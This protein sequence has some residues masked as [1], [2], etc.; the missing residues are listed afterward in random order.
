MMGEEEKVNAATHRR[1]A[2]ELFN[3]T[4]DLMEKKDRMKEE[5]ER[6]VHAA[7]SSR[8][9]W[10]E[11]GEPLNLAVGEWQIARVYSTLKRPS[12]ALRHARRCLEIIEETGIT[13]FYCAS[14]YEG[15]AKATAS[16]ARGRRAR[17]TLGS[18]RPRA[19]ASRT[20]RRGR[21]SWTSWQKSP[22]TVNDLSLG[23]YRST[24]TSSP[25]VVTG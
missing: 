5:D 6:M 20:R 17:N 19:G 12:S 9:H 3:H 24:K 23:A 1:L 8:F 2:V 15:L 13:G 25:S 4:W 10:G 14:A 16:P 18:R 22:S 11:V 21:S 7:H